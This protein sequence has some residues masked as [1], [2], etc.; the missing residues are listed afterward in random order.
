[1]CSGLGTVRSGGRLVIAVLLVL[2]CG[3]CSGGRTSGVA[4]SAEPTE[5]AVAT[6]VD[7]AARLRTELC[8]EFEAVKV[9]Y[10]DS[11]LSDADAEGAWRSIE[12]R[13]AGDAELQSAIRA[14]VDFFSAGGD[15][16]PKEVRAVCASAPADAGSLPTTDPVDEGPSPTPAPTCAALKAVTA[17]YRKVSSPRDVDGAK[18]YWPRIT[19]NNRSSFTISAQMSGQGKATFHLAPETAP[20]VTW[21]HT[22]T[23]QP[24]Q[25]LSFADEFSGQYGDDSLTVYSGEKIT[26]FVVTLVAEVQDVDGTTLLSCELPVAARG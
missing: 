12:I 4:P 24:G 11:K 13:A 22:E 19:V 20:T 15:A 10:V 18:S 5:T 1:M 7:A 3:G 6:T 23:V 21:G 16:S 25:T 26:Q 17:S 2:I 9:D 8:G 14:F